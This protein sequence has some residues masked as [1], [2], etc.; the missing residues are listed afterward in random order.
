MMIIEKI[1]D[2]ASIIIRL[3]PSHIDG[4]TASCKRRS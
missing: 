2:Y 4:A 1:I 3:P